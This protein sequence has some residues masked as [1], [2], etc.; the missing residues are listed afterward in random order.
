MNRNIEFT[1]GFTIT[2]SQ[3]TQHEQ[4]LSIMHRT[5][6]LLTMAVALLLDTP[7]AAPTSAAGEGP[8]P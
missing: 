2:N 5:H 8:R 7:W 1:I 4:E 6:C 3:E